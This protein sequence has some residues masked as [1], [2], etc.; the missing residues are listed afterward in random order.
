[1]ILEDA[2][3][4][5]DAFDVHKSYGEHEVLKGITSEV[6][7]GEVVCLLGPSGSGKSTFLRCV[8]QLEKPDVGSIQING[9]LIGYERR[10]DKLFELSDDRLAAQRCMT[11]MVF[12][13]FNLFGHLNAIE[14][15]ML[16]P[17][18]VLKQDKDETRHEAE[19]LLDQ[20][21]LKGR[22]RAYPSQLSGGQQQR[23]AIA[24]ALAMKPQLM[25]FD[26]PTS[27]LDPQLVGEVLSVIRGLAETGMSMMIVTH[28]ISFARSV[29]DKV[30]FMADG[31]VIEVGPPSQVL[32]NPQ[33]ERT[34]EFL[35]EL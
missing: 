29:A 31:V 16:A 18:L 19:R 13:N 9:E 26:E 8:N 33:A 7:K 20:V 14:N 23:V 3:L 30:M 21:G 15:I 22:E 28:E 34:I 17:R 24:R 4:I 1:M 35:S 5:L 25:L 2:P 6:M 32:D 10:G 12:Q 27:A 11:G